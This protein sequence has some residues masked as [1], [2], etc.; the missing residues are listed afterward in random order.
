[1]EY[2]AAH[3]ERQGVKMLR[4]GE[5]LLDPRLIVFDKDGTLIAF[6]AMWHAWFEGLMQAIA[7]QTA[8]DADT[9]LG[10][11]ATLG[12]DPI[13]GTWDPLGPLTLAATNEVA[14]LTASQLYR[15]QHKPW[16]EAL[17]IVTQAEEMARAALPLEDLITPIGDV[18]GT[19]QR[20][21]GQGLLLALATTDYRGAT[22]RALAKLGLSS[23]FATTVCGDDGIPVKPAP[24][25]ALEI[26]RRLNVAPCEAIM[27]GDTVVDLSM[28]RQAGFAW[29]IGVTSGALTAQA[30]A[31]YADLI[32][33]DIHAIEIVSA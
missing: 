16:G 33:P 13:T 4:I 7:E 25:M 5:R 28:A 9:R 19:L 11:A 29:A 14:L 24:D 10:L 22:E 31:P 3:D 12:Y 8:L 6:E 32:V 17:A 2:S 1:M 26:C 18:R 27:V 30:L 23:L 21:K 20:L 15:H